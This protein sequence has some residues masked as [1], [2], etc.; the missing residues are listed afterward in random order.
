MAK[1]V[2]FIDTADQ[3]FNPM[4]QNKMAKNPITRIRGC[5]FFL[6][7]S[8]VLFF[9]FSGLQGSKV[10]D[11]VS[12]RETFDTMNNNDTKMSTK[13]R[14]SQWGEPY[15]WKGLEARKGELN[16]QT[17][18]IVIPDHP[19]PGN[20]WLWKTEFL[21]A[22]ANAEVELVRRGYYLVHLEMPNH[23]GCPK[24]V[25]LGEEMV[26]TLTSEFGFAPEVG[27]IGM[28]RGG[29]WAFNWAIQ[30]P[31]KTAFVWGD[32]PVVDFKSWPGGKGVGPGNETNWETCL[33]VYELTEEEAL[34]WPYNP[35]DQLEV[36]AKAD[37]PVL[38]VYGDAD[39][40]VPIE[41]NALLVKER[42]LALGG[43]Y[44][45]IVKPGGKHHPHG[46]PDDPTPIVN[47]V[48]EHMR[49]PEQ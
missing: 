37:I 18:H 5:C 48:E 4:N 13:N 34:V 16:S 41:E 29:L 6:T 12:E 17:V 32:N 24:A 31:E 27:L 21:G 42:Y 1:G 26:E 8:M 40:V 35:V 49:S 33:E 23:L 36:L 43:R 46:L 20:L 38:L 30:N 45:E 14:L 7:A 15:D 47:F 19:K 9:S 2:S 11:H 25:A 28:S 22:F 39:E 10:E 3:I 44:E